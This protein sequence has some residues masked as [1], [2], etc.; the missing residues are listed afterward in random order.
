MANSD[1]IKSFTNQNQESYAD[2]AKARRVTPV[3]TSGNLTG[4]QYPLCVDGDSIYEKDVDVSNSDIGG[5]SGAVID[6][7]N[8]VTSNISDTSATNPKFVE[9]ALNRPHEFLEITISTDTGDFSNVKII[10]KDSQGTV[11]TTI[12]DSSSSTKHTANTYVAASFHA[13]TLRFEFH[14]ADTVTLGFIQVEKIRHQVSHLHALKPDGTDTA[15]DAT[16]GGNLKISLEEYDSAFTSN[17]LPVRDPLL[18]ISRGL[19]TGMSTVTKFGRNIEIDSGVKAD[20]WDGGQTVASGGTS[21]IWLPPTQA[22]TH[23]IISTSDND[24][25]TGGTNPQS[26]GAR[27]L[28]VHGLSDWDTAE[29]SEDIV[30]DGTNGVVTSNSYVIIHRMQVLTKGNNAAGPNVGIITATATTDGTVTALIRA[31]QGQ[32][33]MAIYG[34]PSTQKAYMG[35]FYANVNKAGGASGL[36]DVK[37]CVNPEPDAER[38]NYLVKHTFGLQTVGTSAFSIPYYAPKVIAGPAIIKVQILSG[39]NDMDVSAGFDMVLVNN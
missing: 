23:T 16:A 35:R 29:V 7:F 4:P 3:D 10:A 32:T 6:L 24:S 5:F 36:V 31:T 20:I 27:T 25:D 28:R 21:L 1:T 22:R 18:S 38:L 26:D 11:V 37:L 2:D 9:V 19:I 33:Q 13:S 8:S 39:T 30:M 12:D 34:I 17:P 14:T 15:I